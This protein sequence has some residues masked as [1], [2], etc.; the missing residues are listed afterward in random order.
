MFLL[1]FSAP[2]KIK[3][4][5]LPVTKQLQLLHHRTGPD[6]REQLILDVRSLSTSADSASG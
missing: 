1:T 3:K 4:E 2:P 6:G 5:A